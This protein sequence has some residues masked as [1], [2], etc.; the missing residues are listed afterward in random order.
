MRK[1]PVYAYEMLAPIAYLRPAM[2]IP[3]CHH[4][5]WDGSGYPRG[6]HG[7][8]IPFAARLFTVVDVWDA[9][10]SGR[11]Y[12]EALPRERVREYIGANSGSLFDPQMVEAFLETI[13]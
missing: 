13:A 4:E 2:D 9:L 11:P 10:S 5:H 12:R 7:E 1:H 3:Y 6:L 8:E